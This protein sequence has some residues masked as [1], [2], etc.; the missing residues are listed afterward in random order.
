MVDGL[1]GL[2]HHP[3]V[4]R[5]NQNHKIGDLRT[6]GTHGGKRLMAGGV[7]KGDLAF[8][9]GNVIGADVL[10]NST[11]LVFCYPGFTD[12]IEQGGFTVVNMPH[13]GNHRRA[14]L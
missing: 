6:A 14:F 13:D 1:Q 11:G 3:V 4:S 2:G 7:Q 9:G 10:R 8:I 5:N 12:N